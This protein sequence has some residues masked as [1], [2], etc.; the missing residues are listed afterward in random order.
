[1]T[2]MLFYYLLIFTIMLK[3]TIFRSLLHCS[4]TRRKLKVNVEYST[5]RKYLIATSKTG[6]LAKFFIKEPATRTG[7][8]I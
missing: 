1:M 7:G 2:V 3:N 8:L 5:R 4:I 6:R